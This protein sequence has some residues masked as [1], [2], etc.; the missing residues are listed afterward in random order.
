[1]RVARTIVFVGNC[2]LGSLASLYRHVVPAATGDQVVYLASY[3]DASDQAR[4]TL[5]A[6][7]IVVR[8][9]LDF[10]PRIGDLKTRAAVHLVPHLAAPFLWPCT[11]QP[12]PLNAPHPYS[13][14][15]GPYN[16]EIGDS[17]LNRL[18]LE[19][20]DPEEAVNQYMAADV[21]SLRRV[22][23]MQEIVL[24]RQRARDLACGYRFADFVDAH[25][26]TTRLFRT[27]NHPEMSLA[28]VLA[29]E[30]FGRL[31]LDNALIEQ[32]RAAPPIAMFPPTEAPIHPS[33]IAHYGLTWADEA[34][35]YRYFDE[36]YFSFSEYATRY[37]R[38]EWNPL[39][40]EGYHL[41]REG[42][43]FEAIILLR[44]AVVRSP[45]S[46]AGHAV[47]S[48]LLARAGE[49]VEAA[50]LAQVA[51]D[52]EPANTHYRSRLEHLRGLVQAKVSS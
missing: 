51:F 5:E 45:R 49:L 39:L 35:R 2:Q 14:P 10:V 41:A 9:V 33:V 40:G 24:E 16:A 47:L 52:L 25:F 6:A 15:S 8:Q 42:Q 50:N 3:E 44:R 4:R 12:H 21:A 13:D 46:A 7:D 30:V 31:G 26:R 37:M 38:Y 18:I 34:T 19:G 36:G 11:G 32:M 48:D 22:D 27:P 43:I 28:M 29:A 1:M 20:I 23:R 17:F